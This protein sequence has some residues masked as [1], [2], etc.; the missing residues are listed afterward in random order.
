MK[1]ITL[2]VLSLVFTS[3]GLVPS[4]DFF[5]QMEDRQEAMFRPRADFNVVSGDTGD[6]MDSIDHYMSRV[7]ADSKMLKDRVQHLSLS[8]ELRDLEDRL[9]VDDYNQYS[10]NERSFRTVSEKIYYLKMKSGDQ[11]EA[12]L[13]NKGYRMKIRDSHYEN[14]GFNALS[15]GMSKGEIL[16]KFGRPISK[17]IAGSSNNENE[18][19]S[20]HNSGK[21]RYIY[22]ESGQVDGW[23]TNNY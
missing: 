3:C 13:E 15:T 16:K 22:F 5:N 1:V 9:S 2:L 7:P 18:R 8:G 12:Y 21:M 6:T 11:R 10:E 19:W 23:S 17:D 4:R 20:Y 14:G